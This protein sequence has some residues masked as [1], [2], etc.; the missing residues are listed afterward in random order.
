MGRLGVGITAKGAL[1]VLKDIKAEKSPR[2]DYVYPRTLEKAG[3]GIAG[4]LAEIFP[5]SFATGEV[6]LVWNAANLVPLFNKGGKS[7][8]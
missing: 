7:K 4:A 3:E 6:L 8:L 5:L 1:N 2:P